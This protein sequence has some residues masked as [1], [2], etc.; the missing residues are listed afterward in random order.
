MSATC[1]TRAAG[2]AANNDARR[3]CAV[4]LLAS[5]DQ[6]APSGRNIDQN[7]SSRKVSS[8]PLRTAGFRACSDTRRAHEAMVTQRVRQ[9]RPAAGRRSP[10]PRTADPTRAPRRTSDAAPGSGPARPAGSAAERPP[11]CRGRPGPAPGS[12]GS[13]GWPPERDA[14]DRERT[15]VDPEQVADGCRHRSHARWHLPAAPPRDGAAVGVTHRGQPC[16]PA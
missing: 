15:G 2:S 6:F 4:R 10:R 8:P 12:G 5:T 13:R 16:R 9:R 11:R 14:E 3:R 1:S 7:S